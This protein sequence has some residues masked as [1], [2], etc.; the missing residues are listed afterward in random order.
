MH[1]FVNIVA[2]GDYGDISISEKLGDLRN[3]WLMV[4]AISNALWLILISTLAN[5]GQLLNVF[6]SNIVGR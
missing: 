3:Q 6:G 1:V 2:R 4:F 5:Q